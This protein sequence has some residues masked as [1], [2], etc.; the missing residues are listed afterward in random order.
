MNSDTQTRP[1]LDARAPHTPKEAAV[2]GRACELAYLPANQGREEFRL[3]LRLDAEL[4]SMNN[5]QVYVAHDDHSILIA[6]RGS[7]SFATLDGFKDWLLTNARNFLVIPEGRIGTD[8]SAAGVGARFHSGFMGAIADIWEPFFQRVDGLYSQRERPV[9]L[10]GHSLGGAL[11]LLAG[12]R[13]ERHFI[14]VTRICTFGAP[15]IGNDAAAASFNK[16][17]K[18]RIFRYVDDGDIVPKLPTVSLFSNS[19]QHCE[20]EIPVAGQNVKSAVQALTSAAAQSADGEIDVTVSTTLWDE[21]R[22]GMPSHLMGNYLKRLN[23][24]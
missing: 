7:E 8:Y 21:L 4:I 2:L 6:F 13:L 12:W 1:L 22:N 11:A 24:A 17:F 18:R 14:P 3:Q 20:Q 10:T 16:T 19:Y 5:T 23:E 15:M 9:W